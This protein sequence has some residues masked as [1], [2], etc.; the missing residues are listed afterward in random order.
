MMDKNLI[1]SCFDNV[2]CANQEPESKT[3]EKI[4]SE[5]I[6]EEE[7][8][9][10][11]IC[12]TREN[13]EFDNSFIDRKIS[14][15]SVLEPKYSKVSLSSNLSGTKQY[16]SETIENL[17]KENK[18]E[19]DYTKT[20]NYMAKDEYFKLILPEIEKAKTKSK[21]NSN[22]K[23]NINNNLNKNLNNIQNKLENVQ[24]KLVKIEIQNQN[25]L[26]LIYYNP[27]AGYRYM[28]YPYFSIPI[29][30]TE[31]HQIIPKDKKDDFRNIKE[32]SNIKDE[33]E[34][35][36]EEP[37]NDEIEVEEY[38]TRSQRMKEKKKYYN[39]KFRNN[40]YGN[41]YYNG[42]KHYQSNYPKSYKNYNRS[43][44]SEY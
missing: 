6:F 7:E 9:E 28:L 30:F 2:S 26:K 16:Y 38:K 22:K 21:Q 36:V 3:E 4:E 10:E 41:N 43:N 24:M 33:E 23:I 31:K 20:Q 17:K 42:N 8:N 40:N 18:A 5:P 11:E 27:K 12:D 39:K 15:T 34:P 13:S 19:F 14:N 35:K 25:F 32:G 1:K 37:K 29:R 44:Q